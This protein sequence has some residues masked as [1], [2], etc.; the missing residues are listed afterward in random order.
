MSGLW[1]ASDNLRRIQAQTQFNYK[2]AEFTRYQPAANISTLLSDGIAKINYISYAERQ[3]LA[4]G[5]FYAE[6]GS[7][8]GFGFIPNTYA[9]PVFTILA[10]T[11]TR[12]FTYTGS[13]I[14]YTLPTSIQ[15]I[16]SVNIY[17]WGAGGYSLD[18]NAERGGGG[19]F[20]SGTANVTGVTTLYVV[21]GQTNGGSNIQTGGGGTAGRGGGG[22]F[23][24]VFKSNSLV[25]SNLLCCA[26]GGGGEGIFGT[27][28]GAGGLTTG[29][30]ATSSATGG[31]QSAGGTQG[32]G[33]LQ[34]GNAGGGEGGGGGGY[35]GG[36]GGYS[37]VG[38]AGAGGSS[39]TSL[40]TNF[41][42]EG[43]KMGSS[44]SGPFNPG[45]ISNQYYVSPYGK[46]S[47]PGYVVITGT[48][49]IQ[50]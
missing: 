19:A 24:G 44:G 5:K 7:T 45:G 47:Q 35:Y 36:G 21:V 4:T 29:S 48:F 34:G 37:S 26:G 10:S 32:G 15:P 43:G 25:L 23:S 49:Y 50:V 3:S 18:P 11:F 12:A 6:G 2:L 30:N 33:L 27:Y 14:T 31:T 38:D 46:S 8:I 42:G 17:A 41:V 1:D 16:T 13:L 9:P 28:G 20:I 40:L 22:G 39:Y